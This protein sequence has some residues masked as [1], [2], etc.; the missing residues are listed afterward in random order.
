MSKVLGKFE[1]DR[2]THNVETRGEKKDVNWEKPKRGE[3]KP[4]EGKT[5]DKTKVTV[6]DV[7]GEPIPQ[8]MGDERDIPPELEEWDPRT[9]REIDDFF[10]VLEGKRRTG[11]STFARW[12]LQ[13]F[14][15]KFALVWV[16]TNTKA[17]HFWQYFVGESYVFDG[18]NA[19]AVSQLLKINNQIRNKYCVGEKVPDEVRKKCATLIILDD[20]ISRKLHDDP[21]VQAL[22]TR[23]RHHLISV[24]MMLQDPKGIGPATRDNTDVSVIFNLKTE[25]NKET[26]WADFM[27]DARKNLAY[28]MFAKYCVGHNALVALQYVLN[29]QTVLNF[30]KS[31]SDKTKLVD[32]EYCL[33]GPKQVAKIKEERL[34]D[35]KRKKDQVWKHM[36]ADSELT[37]HG[38]LT[39][40]KILNLDDS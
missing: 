34:D 3:E 36:G 18:W 17:N 39:W 9:L 29:G 5:W 1:R 20:V 33:G 19:F 25:R 4:Q 13:Y 10:L 21:V 26:L 27:N 7:D 11:K 12:L 28:N 35:K 24:I 31:T 16:M 23:G 14:Q 8:F 6:I 37:D 38:T 22:A 32:E 40:R 30:M 2:V 15:D